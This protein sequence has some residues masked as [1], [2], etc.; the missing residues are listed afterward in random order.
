MTDMTL[1]KTLTIA[2]ALAGALIGPAAFAQAP[3]PTALVNRPTTIT[4]IPGVVAAGSKWELVNTSLD[5][6]DGIIGTADGGLLIS[7]METNI[8][9]KLEPNG[10][11]SMLV[12]AAP[13]AGG[14]S[15]DKD[16]GVYAVL[17]EGVTS[18][19]KLYPDRRVLAKALPDGKPIPRPNDLVVDARGGAYFAADGAYYVSPQ[20]VVSTVADQNIRSNGITLSTDGKV[21]YVSNDAEV[22]AWDVRPDGSTS[23]RR[24]FATLDGDTGGDGM[25]VDSANRLYETGVAGIH[26]YAPDGRHL[27]MIPTLRRPTA[28]AFSGPGKKILYVVMSGA[29][30]ADGGV[31]S[32]AEG[33]T[34]LSRSIYKMPVLATGWKGW[35]K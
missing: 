24:V 25:T 2:T 13:G 20:G 28:V 14:M 34:G 1:R 5:L 26:V 30:K 19:V 3:P 4:A 17:R 18:V 33:A 35:P 29:T 8:V 31:L 10:A 11:F 6:Q 32:P 9:Q 21:L 23:N 15:Q 16:G 27:G 7:H 22:D 12:G